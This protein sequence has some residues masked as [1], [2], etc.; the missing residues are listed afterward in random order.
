MIIDLHAHT[1]MSRCGRDWPTRLCDTMVA[2]GVEVLGIT[3]HHYG[4]EDYSYDA[5][6][7]MISHLQECYAGRLKILYGIEVCTRPNHPIERGDL[8]EY[9]YCL[10][11]DLDNPESLMGGDLLSYTASFG[12][13]VG[14]AHTD[15]FAFIKERGWEAAAYLEALAARGVFWEMNVNRDSTHNYREHA[16]VKTFMES[17]EQQEL[18]RRAGLCL[19]VG[20]DGHVAAEYD[21]SRVQAMNNFL[22]E[23]GIKNA[24]PTLIHP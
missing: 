11:E 13:P 22:E 14:I 9:D 20:F 23:R 3:D 1:R 4:V 2:N 18:V 17:E 21:V 12:C 7:S 5:Y 10:V 19:S 8:S 15:L 16:Y 24:Y 6:R